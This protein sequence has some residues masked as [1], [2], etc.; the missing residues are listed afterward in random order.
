MTLALTPVSTVKPM[1]PHGANTSP[2]RVVCHAGG[3][4]LDTHD[5]QA[6]ADYR[7]IHDR[8]CAQYGCAC[9]HRVL[10]RGDMHTLCCADA[11]CDVTVA[12][13]LSNREHQL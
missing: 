10:R 4:Y 8:D 7:V 12:H 9:T 1:R 11:T 6:A 2:W 3:H 5:I 13:L